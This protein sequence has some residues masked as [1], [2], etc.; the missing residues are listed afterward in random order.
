MLWIAS[1]SLSHEKTYNCIK[2]TNVEKSSF[3]PPSVKKKLCDLADV[4][5]LAGILTNKADEAPGFSLKPTRHSW[6]V[7]VSGIYH[8]KPS[9]M[10]TGQHRTVQ[11]STKH[12]WL[13]GTLWVSYSNQHCCCCCCCCRAPRQSDT[14][15]NSAQVCLSEG[16]DRISVS[17]HPA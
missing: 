1:V 17:L 12:Q 4:W 10:R 3:L 14:E 5:R 15:Q 11:G 13:P 7:A 6:W 9:C 8:R 2:S 16:T